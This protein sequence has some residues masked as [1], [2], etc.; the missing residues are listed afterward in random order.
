M[1]GNVTTMNEQQE[2]IDTLDTQL[3]QQQIQLEQ[4]H[5]E[6][7]PGQVELVLA[8]Q[9]DPIRMADWVVMTR[10]TITAVAKSHGLVALFLPKIHD[11]KAGNGCHVHLSF[12]ETNSSRSN[13]FPHATLN[14]EMSAVAK[15]F[16]EGILRHLPALLSL[17]MPT[18]NSF[19]R[20]GPGCWTGSVIGWEMEDKEAALRVCMDTA[21]GQWTN[22][23]YKLCDSTAN[24]YLALSG[25]LSC[26]LN[27]IVQ[28]LTLRPAL[29]QEESSSSCMEQDSQATLPSSLQESLVCLQKDEF[30]RKVVMGAELSKA[31]IAVRQ[32]ASEKFA[33][34]SLEEEVAMALKKS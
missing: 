21:T 28:H 26:G 14:G 15:S 13:A 32:A 2:F 33:N 9:D 4:I 12:R 22:V 30:L 10:E 7:A 31:Y 19:R 8:Y 29:R 3:Q 34:L 24:L 27:G 18:D 17:T 1:F 11:D 5:A 16:L 6:S 23:E 25:I 20:V